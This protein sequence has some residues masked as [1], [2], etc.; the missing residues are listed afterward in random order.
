[1]HWGPYY[2]VAL[3]H[4]KSR[5]FIYFCFSDLFLSKLARN[6]TNL[7]FVHS[8][9]GLPYAGCTLCEFFNSPLRI[10]VVINVRLTSVK[11]GCLQEN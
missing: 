8:Y 10:S 2:T 5:I 3:K 11:N 6:L 1:M 4:G 7:C 9:L